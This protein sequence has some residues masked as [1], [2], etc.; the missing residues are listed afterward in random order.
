[1][2]ETGRTSYHYPK[3]GKYQS[4]QFAEK[5]SACATTFRRRCRERV[6]R[7]SGEDASIPGGGR[8]E[9]MLEDEGAKREK[10][11]QESESGEF[12]RPAIGTPAAKQVEAVCN[13]QDAVH[14]PGDFDRPFEPHPV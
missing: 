1:K 10:R 8:G 11:R 2:T 7:L 13:K 5:W 14:P 9:A 6:P 12:D 3:F 4:G